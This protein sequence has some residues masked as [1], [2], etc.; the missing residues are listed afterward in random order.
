MA[1]VLK[2]NVKFTGDVSKLPFSGMFDY[3]K[4]AMSIIG[5]KK[6]LASY[7]GAILQASKSDGAVKDIYATSTGGLDTASLL[8]FV[9]SGDA[10]VSK[11]YDQT[12]NGRDFARQDKGKQPFIVK[13]GEVVMTETGDPCVFFEGIGTTGKALFMENPP[14]TLS[15]DLA[16][17][18]DA[19]FT[20]SLVTVLDQRDPLKTM[21]RVTEVGGEVQLM[22]RDNLA[23]EVKKLIYG[24]PA[25]KT[26]S[27][28]ASISK[29]D[30][31]VSIKSGDVADTANLVN[32]EPIRSASHVIIGSSSTA[33]FHDVMQGYFTTLA[34]TDNMADIRLMGK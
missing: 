23:G 8:A 31:K 15:G 5:T 25:S 17:Y 11:I 32:Y 7:Q 4:G 20:N 29:T 22:Y 18:A 24:S 1:I 9:G 30:N 26:K 2:S 13:G 21:F 34:I 16:V 14:L 28:F 12:N 27:Y 3:L 19:K 6:L 33:G 10:T